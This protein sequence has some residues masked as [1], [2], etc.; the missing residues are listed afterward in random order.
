MRREFLHTLAKTSKAML[1][2]IYKALMEDCS[3]ASSAAEKVLMIV[4]Q[5]HFST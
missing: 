2:N 1:R 4:L 3:A 5:W